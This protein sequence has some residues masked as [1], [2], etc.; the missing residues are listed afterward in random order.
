[1]VPLLARVY[2]NGS[3]DV[4]QFQAA[5]GPGF[6]MRELL[7]AGLMHADVLTAR[8]RPARYTQ[9]PPGHGR[10]RLAGAICGQV[11]RRVHRAARVQALQPTGGLKLL[12]GNLG[13]SGDQGL[14]RAR[15]P[16][17]RS[18]RRPA[19]SIRRRPLLAAFKAGELERDVV[20]VVRFQGPRPTACPSCTSSRRRWRC[21]RARASRWRW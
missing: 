9:A 3:A 13:R 4:N 12:E 1:V 10:Q 15:G 2:P 11:G 21:C 14:G 7:D 16:P 8:R 5:G 6:V 18:R 20:A 19:S 17:C